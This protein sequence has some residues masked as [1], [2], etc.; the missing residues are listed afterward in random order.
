MRNNERIQVVI[1]GIVRVDDV[2]INTNCIASIDARGGN[3]RIV[4][5]GNNIY[6]FDNLEI[7]DFIGAWLSCRRV[8]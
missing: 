5:F 1:G 8:D 6:D 3:V 2:Y 4:L 7:E